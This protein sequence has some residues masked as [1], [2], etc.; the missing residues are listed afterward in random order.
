M[1]VAYLNPGERKELI[2]DKSSG[3]GRPSFV[4]SEGLRGPDGLEFALQGVGWDA[5]G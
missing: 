5:R 3:G 1:H 4:E 2:L